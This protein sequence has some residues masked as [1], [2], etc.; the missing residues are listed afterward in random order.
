MIPC[1]SGRC[2]GGPFSC[3]RTADWCLPCGD[4]LRRS[5]SVRRLDFR[6]KRK[7]APLW[8]PFVFH[9]AN[10]R[11][12]TADLRITS[13]LLYQLSHIGKMQFR[14]TRR[15]IITK[16]SNLH[17]DFFQ[18]RASSCA[19]RVASAWLGGRADLGRESIATQQSAG[20]ADSPVRCASP[21]AS[22]V[23]V[24]G[25]AA[26]CQTPSRDAC[27]SCE[28]PRRQSSGTPARK[29]RTAPQRQ[30]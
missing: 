28:Q 21:P 7:M 14:R 2:T 23:A 6:S 18:Y 8:E 16:A 20:P 24:A 3:N 11:I 1:D 5:A 27:R 19:G 30:S 4:Q 10:E 9:G 15:L 13:A 25:V 26:S 22:A 29:S 17:K 12:R